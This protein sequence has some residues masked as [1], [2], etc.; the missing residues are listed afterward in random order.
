MNR[1]IRLFLY[2][3]N[4]KLF[5]IF[6]FLCLFFIFDTSRAET[7]FSN[8]KNNQIDFKYLESRNELENYIIDTG[9]SIYLEFNTADQLS[10]IYPVN[11]EGELFLPRLEETYVR[12]LTPF[13][14]EKLLIKRYA[15]FL[16]KPDI[17]VRIA[18]FKGIK[19]LVRGELRNPGFYTFPA[20]QSASFI[21][22]TK[23][24]PSSNVLLQE[25]EK[26]NMQQFRKDRDA[27]L[28]SQYSENLIIQKSSEKILTISDVIRKEVIS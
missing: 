10:G 26:T 4:S 15:E 13:E 23:R 27:K 9:D 14:L 11:E 18:I 17:D 21:N 16:I 28:M 7:N 2:K 22:F 12:G 6:Y 20:Y 5:F 24:R 3:R 8:T 19:V 1:L 25:V